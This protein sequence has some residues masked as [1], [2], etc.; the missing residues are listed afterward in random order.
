[1]ILYDELRIIFYLV[2]Y[3]FR[4]IFPYWFVGVFVGSLFSVFASEKITKLT[5]KIN[6]NKFPLFGIMF[7][8]I[9]GVLSPICMYGTIPL[10]AV[11]GKKG[12]KQY[13]LATF[14]ISSILINPNLFIFS[15]ALGIQ[16]AFLRLFVCI[17]AGVVAGILVKNFFN[18]KILFDFSGFGEERNCKIKSPGIKTFFKDFNRGILKTAP[19]FLVGIFITALFSRYDAP[20]GIIIN[21][22]SWNKGL[23]VLMASIIGIPIYVCGGGTIPLLKYWL[24][25]GMSLGSAVAFMIS[26]P[27]TKLTNVSAVKI[28]LGIKNFT[29]Y[30]MFAIVFSILSGVTIDIVYGFIRN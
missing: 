15:F 10:I 22:F 12:V 16:L 6:I 25:S 5:S 17:L 20:K 29:L 4:I 28:V 13:Y 18:N 11:L 30:I 9:L 23:G 21:I 14:M 27:A 7:A 19:Y 2:S 24:D 1:M 8:A 3:Q 26:G